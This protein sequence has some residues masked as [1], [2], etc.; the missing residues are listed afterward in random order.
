MN[1][2]MVKTYQSDLFNN[3]IQTD[4]IE[5]ENGIAALSAVN[6]SEGT[7]QIDALN[8]AEK[9]YNM[10]NRVALSGGTYEDWQEAVYTQDAVRKAETPIYEGGMSGEI[11]FEEVIQTA[12]TQIE[13][14]NGALGQ[15]GGK[16]TLI[17]TKGG[18]NIH[19]KARE[20]IFVMGIVSITPRVCYTQGNE[21]YL[22][23][24]DSYDDLHKPALDQIG[25]QDLIL[26]QMAWWDTRCQLVVP[27]QEGPSYF[28]H[29][30]GKVVAWSNYMTA[31]DKAFGE[32]ALEEGKNFMVLARNYSMIGT[33][34]SVGDVTTYID[35]AKFNYAFA[36]AARDA[37]NFWVQLHSRVITRRVMSAHQIPNL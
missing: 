33:T 18:R 28:R 17:G 36:Y 19:I 9:V 21:W 25:F 26:E 12:E 31:V 22:T 23:E 11:M 3:W 5:G 15:L 10:L 32:F 29:S 2:L 8:L 30:A 16:G 27:G 1:G 20:P 35:P 13:G 34:L 24:L 14:Q 7:L 6:V 37:Q 4:W